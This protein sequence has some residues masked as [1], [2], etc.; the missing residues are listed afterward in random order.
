MP[1][2]PGAPHS[3]APPR[4]AQRPLRPAGNTGGHSRTLPLGPAG[5]SAR[6]PHSPRPTW[7]QPG[8]GSRACKSTGTRRFWLARRPKSGALESGRPGSNLN[9]A[10]FQLCDRRQVTGFSGPRFPHLQHGDHSG[11]W[12]DGPGLRLNENYGPQP[13]LHVR[14]T[15]Y[16][17]PVSALTYEAV[18]LSP[19]RQSPRVE[20]AQTHVVSRME[21]T[22]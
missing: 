13:H 15:R 12:S 2:V 16:Q 14:V 21:N 20:T 11:A 1:R 17:D 8:P 4:A 22:L 3:R 9:S 19:L 7:G 6:L 5:P 18:C 10:T